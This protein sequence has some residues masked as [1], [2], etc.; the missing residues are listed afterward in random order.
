MEHE[1][2]LD[3]EKHLFTTPDGEK[4][5]GA[6]P[7]PDMKK[8]VEE[9]QRRDFEIAQALLGKG[10][11][12]KDPKKPTETPQDKDTAQSKDKAS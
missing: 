6:P 1:G 9:A 2:D 5:Y 11:E 8:R 4:V 12:K 10:A 3:H 7:P